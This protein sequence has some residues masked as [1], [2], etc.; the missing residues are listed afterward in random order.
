MPA[1]MANIDT[2]F[3]ISTMYK[4]TSRTVGNAT[5]RQRLP[6]DVDGWR[7]KP[8]HSQRLP[9]TSTPKTK[10][11][12]NRGAGAWT[13]PGGMVL[14][15]LS[16]GED[17]RVKT[18]TTTNAGKCADRNPVGWYLPLSFLRGGTHSDKAA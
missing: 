5:G 12:R 3:T 18:Q 7:E 14:E 13:L 11:D 6:T 10:H 9:G 4:M 16:I 17:D 2:T 15:S 8:L 1:I